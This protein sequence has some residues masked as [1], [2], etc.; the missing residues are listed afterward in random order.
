MCYYLIGATVTRIE[1]FDFYCLYTN[2]LNLHRSV[3]VMHPQAAQA[4][5]G[6]SSFLYWYL[7]TIIL[8]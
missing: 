5:S 7:P 6:K 8:E 3:V 4:R 1:V 2:G